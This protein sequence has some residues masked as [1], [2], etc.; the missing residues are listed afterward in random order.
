MRQNFVFS[1]EA[2]AATVPARAYAAFGI[3]FVT[4]HPQGKLRFDDLD[5]VVICVAIRE[6]YESSSTVA[7]GG[8]A[9]SAMLGF[10]MN[11]SASLFIGA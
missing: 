2:V 1:Y 11:E 5:G 7:R 3:E 6:S 4:G 8:G 10:Y 9:P